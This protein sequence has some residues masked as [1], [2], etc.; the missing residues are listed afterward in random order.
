[1]DDVKFEISFTRGVEKNDKESFISEFKSEAIDIS[2][3]GELFG[4]SIDFPPEIYVTISFVGVAFAQWILGKTF[5][6]TWKKIKRIFIKCKNKKLKERK[7]V[8]VINFIA[9]DI[10][11]MAP[12]PET[13]EYEID[14][15]LS[16]LPEYL[17]KTKA[18][19]WLR[20]D[21]KKKKWMTPLE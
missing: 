10:N 5:D 12:L 16:T 8:I 3:D 6:A 15:A 18:K 13:T 21:L 9:E 17:V 20:F 7:P 11:I 19:G 2:E 14:E 1:M 4:K